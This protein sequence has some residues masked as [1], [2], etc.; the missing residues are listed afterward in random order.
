MYA[1]HAIALAGI[2]V[3]ALAVSAYITSHQ[4]LRL[5]WKHERTY[6]AE[7]SN[8]QA[9]TPGQ[10]QT[11]NVAGVEV[12]EIGEVR[13]ENGVGVGRMD[14]SSPDLKQI[15]ANTHLLLRPETGL[16]DMSVSLDP[17]APHPA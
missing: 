1:R 17:G 13:L 7:F 5:P 9:V 3:L 8:A 2:V 16:D 14:I 12:G 4:R 11:V 15:Y 10:G 6:Y